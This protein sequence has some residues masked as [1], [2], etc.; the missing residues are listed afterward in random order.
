MKITDKLTTENSKNAETHKKTS[1]I[2]EKTSKK[3][4]QN[5][6]IYTKQDACYTLPYHEAPES[7]EQKPEEREGK[8]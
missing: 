2:A 3:R 5:T 8:N 6:T 7:A 1:K 4:D